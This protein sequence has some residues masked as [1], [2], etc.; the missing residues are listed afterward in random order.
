MDASG[1][2]LPIGSTI[3][4]LTRLLVYLCADCSVFKV[5]EGSKMSLYYLA[6]KQAEN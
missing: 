1:N 4:R 6:K 3:L 2:S 5:Q